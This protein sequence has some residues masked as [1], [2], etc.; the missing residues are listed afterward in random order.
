MFV[1]GCDTRAYKQALGAFDLIAFGQ[2]SVMNVC[3]WC[4]P[5]VKYI[6]HLCFFYW[7]ARPRASY[8][9]YVYGEL[10]SDC[11]WALRV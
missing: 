6:V 2:Q 1:V 11:L 10:E 3:S 4:V 8:I 7:I 5:V 9:Y